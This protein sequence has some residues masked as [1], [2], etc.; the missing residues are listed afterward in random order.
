MIYILMSN[1]FMTLR[2]VAVLC[3]FTFGI[4]IF[5]RNRMDMNAD[6]Q[7][8]G[9]SESEVGSDDRAGRR[10]KPIKYCDDNI[11]ALFYFQN[12]SDRLLVWVC[13]CFVLCNDS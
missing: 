1:N 11:F 10:V 2:R 8:D 7:H 5:S 12:V 13:L 4:F 3:F 9:V 6:K